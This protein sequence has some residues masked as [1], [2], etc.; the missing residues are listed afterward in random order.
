[1]A[2]LHELPT[3][4]SSFLEALQST[5]TYKKVSTIHLAFTLK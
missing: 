5:H 1:L 2:L 3:S 4:S